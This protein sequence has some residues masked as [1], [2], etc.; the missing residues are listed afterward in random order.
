[1][2]PLPSAVAAQLARRGLRVLALPVAASVSSADGY[3]PAGA[4]V[5]LTPLPWLCPDGAVRPAV[6]VVASL[7]LGG[8]RAIVCPGQAQASLTILAPRR[9]LHP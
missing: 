8:E 4:D 6:L 2:T 5:T 3:V 1:M 7:A 9:T